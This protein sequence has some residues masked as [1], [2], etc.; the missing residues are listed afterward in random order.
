MKLVVGIVALSLPFLTWFLSWRFGG[1]ALTSISAAYWS[2][3]PARG[4]F[5]G[6]LFAIASFLLA[7]NG[8]S[9]PEMISSKVASVASLGVALFPCQC[10]EAG[11]IS[12]STVHYTSAATLF[13]L[14][15]FFCYFFYKRAIRK[16]HPEAIARSWIYVASG[17]AIVASIVVLAVNGLLEDALAERF[18]SLKFWGEAT[19][20]FAFGVSWLTASRTLPVITKPSERF[21]PLRDDNP[22]D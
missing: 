13:V 16:G 8:F 10:D 12:S 17:V 18:T 21:S 22:D 7:Y 2:G 9:R 15:V 4:V 19:G 5:I 11:T 3:G 14:L 1:P 6:F 20:L